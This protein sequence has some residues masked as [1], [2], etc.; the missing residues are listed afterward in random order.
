MNI[1]TVL[2][3][4]QICFKRTNFSSVRKSVINFLKLFNPLA[5]FCLTLNLIYFRYRL[6]FTLIKE[7]GERLSNEV[8]NFFVSKIMPCVEIDE[9]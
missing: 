2:Q 3:S 4:F 5:F 6:T 7:Q 8:M 1:D 9:L